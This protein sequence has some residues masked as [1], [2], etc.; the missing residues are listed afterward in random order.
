MAQVVPKTVSF[1]LLEITAITCAT[2][3]LFSSWAVHSGNEKLFYSLHSALRTMF[4]HAR[5]VTCTWKSSSR[6]T[7]LKASSDCS[8]QAFLDVFLYKHYSASGIYL[9]SFQ[10]HLQSL[11][12][13]QPELTHNLY[14]EKNCLHFQNF[15]A[16]EVGYNWAFFQFHTLS[17]IVHLQPPTSKQSKALWLDHK[18]ILRRFFVAWANTVFQFVRWNS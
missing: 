4:N 2:V 8:S 6:K 15:Y 12:W 10:P 18:R 5:L 9:G 7:Y 17:T 13:F 14:L 11:V 16:I 1:L 3:F